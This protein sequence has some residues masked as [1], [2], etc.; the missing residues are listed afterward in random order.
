MQLK[1]STLALLA[2]SAGAAALRTGSTPQVVRPEASRTTHAANDARAPLVLR[3]GASSD[4]ALSPWVVWWR[5]LC[6][7]MFPGNPPRPRSPPEAAPPAPPAPAAAP[8]AAARSG[9]AAA[10]P[11]RSGGAAGG[12]GAV[13]AV[14]SKAELD[15][16][17][18]SA[19]KKQLVVVDFFATWCGPCQQIAPKY[20]AMASELTHVRFVKVG[21]TSRPRHRPPHDARAQAPAVSPSPTADRAARAPVARWTSTSARIFSRSTECRPCQRSR[22]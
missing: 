20:A 1:A 14:H 4:A 8:R 2:L 19:T 16:V 5:V 10:R 7:V 12:G 6:R 18:A 21:G 11:K 15:K 22:C 3:G 9:R 13:T 17:L